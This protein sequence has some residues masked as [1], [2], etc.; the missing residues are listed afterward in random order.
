MGA[1]GFAVV[2]LPNTVSELELWGG[3]PRSWSC[4]PTDA[5]Y[6]LHVVPKATMTTAASRHVDGTQTP[7]S[8]RSIDIGERHQVQALSST[9]RRESHTQNI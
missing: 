5:K 2:V 3:V 4:G 1:V 9:I 7:R 6:H 8:F